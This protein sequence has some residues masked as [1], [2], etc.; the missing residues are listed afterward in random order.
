M[1]PEDE[2][3]T[4]ETTAPA[5]PSGR[6]SRRTEG[7]RYSIRDAMY[8]TV[9]AG[10][11]MKAALV[12]R[13]A[14]IGPVSEAVVRW[15]TPVDIEN[16]PPLP[17]AEYGECECSD[18]IRIAART[19]FRGLGRDARGPQYLPDTLID[20]LDK[21][22][23]RPDMPKLRIS[24]TPRFVRGEDGAPAIRLVA[25]D[26]PT[27]CLPPEERQALLTRVLAAVSDGAP[28]EDL[29]A[30]GDL[31]T[32]ERGPYVRMAA[33]D[34]AERDARIKRLLRSAISSVP[35]ADDDAQRH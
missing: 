15:C 14:D 7:F 23:A 6:R 32:R 3:A 18:G 26:L 21:R 22:S 2:A 10:A 17:P 4:P 35:P 13:D 31:A 33:M 1:R 27:Y 19:Y 8:A 28:P 12:V 30:F 9:A 11:A 24:V 29:A 16:A 20:V 25:H 5:D 34:A